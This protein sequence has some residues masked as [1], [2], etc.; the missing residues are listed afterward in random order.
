M[1]GVLGVPVEATL[2]RLAREE[3]TRIAQAIAPVAG[4]RASPAIRAQAVADTLAGEGY[5][6]RASA[7]QVTLANCPF[8]ALVS[9]Y[10]GRCCVLLEIGTS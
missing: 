4:L 7:G 6:P 3:G 1:D 5:E 9:D 8:S 2:D 10:P